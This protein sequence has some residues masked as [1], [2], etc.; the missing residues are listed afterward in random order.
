MTKKIKPNKVTRSK[1]VEAEGIGRRRKISEPIG[2]IV[3]P[4][5]SSAPPS[6]KITGPSSY[7]IF[8]KTI[9][10][11][12]NLIGIHREGEKCEEHHND[13]FRAAVV[14]SIS[15]L[16]AYVRTLVVEKILTRLS[17]KDKPISNELRDYIK[18]LI[19][20]ESLLEAARKYEFREKVEKAIRADFETK[21]FQG[22]YKI[23]FYMELAGYK[24]IFEEVSHS[25]NKNKNRLRSDI[26]IYTKRRHIIA[27]CGDFDLTSIPHSEN[28]I[29]RK[30]AGD[31]IAVVSLF[32]E[33]INKI[34]K[35]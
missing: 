8:L 35:K 18:G 6:K 12:N 5:T 11:A 32:A 7:D 15:A 25:A 16:D 29:E 34:V 21:S 13:S 17:D 22:E 24:D 28:K 27:H 33:H 31:C 2:E 9:K 1:E 14:L 10:R 23:N 4:A 26:E 30:Y 19:N 20:H 3:A